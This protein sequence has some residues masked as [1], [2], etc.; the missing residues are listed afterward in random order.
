MDK[1]EISYIVGRN[2][3][4]YSHYGIWRFLKNLETQLPYEPAVPLLDI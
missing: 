2:V 3:N 4:W 1:R